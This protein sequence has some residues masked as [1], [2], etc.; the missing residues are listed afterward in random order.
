MTTEI[1]DPSNRT[2]S[3]ANTPPPPATYRLPHSQDM[4]DDP[5]ILVELTRTVIDFDAEVIAAALRDEGIPATVFARAASTL[6]G[7]I[8]PLASIA[9]S[10]RRG[11]LDR[12]K[13]ILADIRQSAREI[14]WSQVDTE[15]ASP[16]SVEELA[17]GKRGICT[18][19]GYDRRGLTADALCPECGRSCVDVPTGSSKTEVPISGTYR[20]RRQRTFLVGVVLIAIVLLGIIFGG[21]RLF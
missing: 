11:D 7:Q 21:L 3:H 8:S 15:D 2:W 20:Q 14:D 1:L 9:V 6:Q 17:G 10:V 18:H 4:G 19:C 13:E 12:A 5:N 16:V